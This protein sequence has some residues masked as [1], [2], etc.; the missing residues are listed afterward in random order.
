MQCLRR[1][2]H[3]AVQAVRNHHVAA[4]RPDV[5]GV[6]LHG[7]T[8]IRSGGDR[9]LLVSVLEVGLLVAEPIGALQPIAYRGVRTVGSDHDVE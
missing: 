3:V 8:A 9:Q 4:P 6:R 2:E 1:P 5:Q 7:E